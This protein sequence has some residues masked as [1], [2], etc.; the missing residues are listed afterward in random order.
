MDGGSLGAASLLKKVW[1]AVQ[2]TENIFFNL[3]TG[4]RVIDFI[5]LLSNETVPDMRR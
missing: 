3:M 4:R 1:G 5:F 2:Q